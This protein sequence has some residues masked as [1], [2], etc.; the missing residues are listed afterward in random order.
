MT[1]IRETVVSA[2]RSAGV[3][4]YSQQSY[5]SYI[6]AVVNA[7]EAQQTPVAGSQDEQEKGYVLIENLV[8][9]GQRLGLGIG[10]YE[11]ELVSTIEQATGL[12]R[13]PAPEP[14]P[15]V[16]DLEALFNEDGEVAE[17]GKKKGKK[18]QKALLGQILT[19]L[20]GI[21]AKQSEQ[22]EV[23]SKLKGLASSRLGVTI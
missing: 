8:A 15:E 12:T 1:T 18:A 7:L 10:R 17:G 11:E 4:E 14:E 6:D 5:Q 9:A 3:S 21:S 13:R 22:D 19:T 20:E 2:L 16:A 23:L